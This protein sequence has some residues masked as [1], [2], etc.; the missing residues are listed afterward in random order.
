MLHYMFFFLK[1][2]ELT[3]EMRLTRYTYL[4]IRDPVSKIQRLGSI[5]GVQIPTVV[6]EICFSS[7]DFV[8]YCRRSLPNF[9]NVYFAK[10]FLFED[11]EN[12]VFKLE[13]LC[14]I[15]SKTVD[16]DR[17][18]AYTVGSQF[19]QSEEPLK[20]FNKFE[21]CGPLVSLTLEIRKRPT[22][23]TLEKIKFTTI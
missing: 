16:F 23:T 4:A 12:T 1:F 18:L 17:Y 14:K 2:S 22:T 8:A 10:S 7:V 21:V 11:E 15:I 5:P 13:V 9:A 19:I 20:N 6:L 3:H